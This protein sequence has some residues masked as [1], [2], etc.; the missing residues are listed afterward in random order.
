M[1]D[2]NNNFTWQDWESLMDVIEKIVT[3]SALNTVEMISLRNSGSSV[4]LKGK[5]LVQHEVLVAT[6]RTLKR[7]A[8]EL[9]DL[10]LRC[11]CKTVAICICMHHS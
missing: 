7:S 4:N 8:G 5:S 3:L 2:R 10:N 1:I 6:A 11:I 9:K